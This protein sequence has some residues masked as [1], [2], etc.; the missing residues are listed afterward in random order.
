ML[1]CSEK[2]AVS[3]PQAVRAKR[4][5]SDPSATLYSSPGFFFL[6]QSPILII[7]SEHGKHADTYFIFFPLRSNTIFRPSL[8]IYAP[9]PGA[10]SRR[11]DADRCAAARGGPG[12]GLPGGCPPA[13]P[14]IKAGGYGQS[15]SAA[16]LNGANYCSPESPIPLRRDSWL[17]FI[18]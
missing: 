14:L 1:K 11:S 18:V 9:V 10:R 17:G 7:L 15:G 8:L 4:R 12:P 3:H 13:I 6:R 2:C 16:A 5:G